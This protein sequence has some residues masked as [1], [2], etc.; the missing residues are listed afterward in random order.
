[1]LEAVSGI[2]L[3]QLFNY[4]AVIIAILS[5]FLEVSKIKINPWTALGRALGKVINKDVIDKLDRMERT[6]AETRQKLDGH[7]RMDDERNADLHRAY[8]LRFNTELLR[9]INH[10][11]EDFNEIFY[12]IDYYERY[13]ADHPE[14]QNNRAVHAI[15][16]IKN[17]YDEHMENDGFLKA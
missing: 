13:C 5:I 8:I 6:Q 16:H 9:G 4:V 11:K 3:G 7:I 14:Y 12:N 15:K 10:T 2:E 17:V 1:M